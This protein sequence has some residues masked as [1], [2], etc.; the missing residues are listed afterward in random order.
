[1]RQ[2]DATPYKKPPDGVSSACTDLSS[3]FEGATCTAGA[4]NLTP[5][6]A[7]EESRLLSACARGSALPWRPGRALGSRHG[8]LLRAS[9]PGAACA[10]P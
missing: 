3:L 6:R 5:E 2:D 1:M 4:L 7:G 8:K 9:H 10:Q